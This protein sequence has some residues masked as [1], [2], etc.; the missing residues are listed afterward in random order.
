MFRT[1]KEIILKVEN[2][3]SQVS[4]TLK[5]LNIYL[6]KTRLDAHANASR[7]VGPFVKANSLK[8]QGVF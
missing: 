8:L 3:P 4:Q 6:A 1:K 5:Q 7:R 2:Q